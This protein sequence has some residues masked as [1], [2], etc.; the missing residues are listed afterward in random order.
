MVKL[1][2]LIN[3]LDYIKFKSFCTH[4]KLF[5]KLKRP[6]TKWEKIFASY[7]SDRGLKTR[8]YRELKKI[9]LP[10]KSMTQ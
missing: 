9:K 1:M 7:I 4:K 10:Q 2:L 3:K 5:S 6:S 8:I